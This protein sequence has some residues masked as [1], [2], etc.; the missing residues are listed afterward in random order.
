M[1]LMFMIENSD[2]KSDLSKHWEELLSPDHPSGK[3][4]CEHDNPLIWLLL[5]T[6][7]L[8]AVYKLKRVT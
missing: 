4:W 1:V 8:S 6:P 7:L 5:Y 2:S 3:W